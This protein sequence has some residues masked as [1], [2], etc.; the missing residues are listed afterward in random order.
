VNAE[1]RISELKQEG[2]KI[3]KSLEET[4]TKGV[5]LKISSNY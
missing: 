2:E 3:K 1:K 4:K 5:H